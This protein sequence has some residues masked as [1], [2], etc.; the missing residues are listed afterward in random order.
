MAELGVAAS[1]ISIAS[2]AIQVGDSILKLKTF[3]DHVK[4]APEEIK[5]LIDEIET[6]N[7]VLSGFSSDETPNGPL[8]IEPAFSSRCLELCRKG[9]GILETV[10]KEIDV[11]IGKRKRVG[12]FKA[13]LKKGTIERLKERMRSAQLML[14]LSNQA[15]SE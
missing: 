3:W 12:S 6:L 11:E 5:Y 1:A 14:M 2:I 13:V 10:V 9:A 8:S 15:Y 7:L 4:E